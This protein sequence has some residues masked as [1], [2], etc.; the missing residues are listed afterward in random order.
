MNQSANSI[1]RA[2]T[3]KY[4]L[5]LGALA[6]LAVVNFLIFEAE[7]RESQAM[8]TV[9]ERCGAQR[10]LIHRTT[11]LVE[12]LVR[13]TDAVER[14]QLR[15]LLFS[16]AEPL[17]SGHEEMMFLQTLSSGPLA[18]VNAIYKDP[19][20]GLDLQ[21]KTYLGHLRTL[22]RA[23]NELL[24]YGNEDFRYL[25]DPQTS[26][27]L[28]AAMDAVFEVYSQQNSIRTARLN[29]MAIWSLLSTIVVLLL[30]GFF[31][32]APMVRRVRRDMADVT[33][34]NAL[35]EERV[36]HQSAEVHY[37]A[38]QLERSESAL[39]ESEA[40]Y[41]S[42]VDHLPLSV[43]RKDCLGRFTFVNDRYCRLLDRPTED[44][45]GHTEEELLP[46]PMAAKHSLDDLQVMSTQSILYDVEEFH[47][48]PGRTTIFASLTVPL[49]DGNGIVTG[50]QTA[51]W[52]ITD[53][54]R[55]EERALHS[56]RL[57][58][59][60]QMVAGVAHES[61]NALQQIQACIRLLEWELGEDESKGDLISDLQ[62]AQD[63]LH[64][65]FD[66][67]QGYAAPLKVNA[68]RCNVSEV[69]S[70][71]WDLVEKEIANREVSFVVRG[72]DVPPD[73]MVDPFQL[74]QVF[75]N[76]LENALAACEDPVLIEVSFD[77]VPLGGQP[78]L[79]ITIRD[80]GP[81][82]TPEQRERI[83]EPF[84]TTKTRGTGLGMAIVK[85]IVDAHGGRIEASNHMT[86]G[87]KIV[88]TLPAAE[89]RELNPALYG[90]LEAGEH[91][92]D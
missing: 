36:E 52:D 60:G 9:V 89:M 83:F 91:E 26:G 16:A 6:S 74:E 54:K 62:S 29:L 92:R 48:S 88:I 18:R 4:L 8:A 53:R 67:L 77:S 76:I 81:G 80:N 70:E 58:A 41:R 40:L 59:I 32:F 21:L 51:L 23:P 43:S 42:L 61:R 22:A 27:N 12:R 3:L 19:Q 64:R 30:S 14:T 2:L 10:S 11:T 35:L 38:E 57:A 46:K 90:H 49:L 44:I 86:Q 47:P 5:A 66:E 7:I 20:E 73:C 69:L 65:L 37:R 72:T 1:T 15:H 75:R 79:E 87:S 50:T 82:L 63:R 24:N 13:T 39:R 28:L 84:Y 31:V 68:R 78:G 25:Q 85:R 34:L 17:E 55:A 71:T 56:E 45:V 33:E